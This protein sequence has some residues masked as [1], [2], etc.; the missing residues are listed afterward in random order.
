MVKRSKGLKLIILTTPILVVIV[1]GRLVI[2]HLNQPS[3]GVVTV[4]SSSTSSAPSF[5]FT[6]Q[7]INGHYASFNYPTELTV[8]K[9]NT[10]VDPVVEEFNFSHRDIETWA[11]A[12]SIMS[13][14]GGS[15]ATN[16]AYQFRKSQPKIYKESHQDVNNQSIDIM[17]DTSVGGFSKV[18]FLEGNGLSAT[19]SLYGDD[20][21]GVGDLSKTLTM[22]ISS[23]KWQ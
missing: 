14:P 2:S 19:V 7:H 21:T 16:N 5:N 12:I 3:L 6:P 11:L 18:A 4:G 10:L 15:L 23:W 13:T 8:S 1:G 22:V 9:N 20:P 17:T